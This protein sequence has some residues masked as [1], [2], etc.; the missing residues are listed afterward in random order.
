MEKKDTVN[1]D[2]TELSKNE[3]CSVIAEKKKK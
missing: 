1:T 2:I 3:G